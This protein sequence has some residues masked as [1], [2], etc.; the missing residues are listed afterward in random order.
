MTLCSHTSPSLLHIPS[1]QDDVLRHSAYIYHLQFNIH[2]NPRNHWIYYCP[3]I[4]L[5]RMADVG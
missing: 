4:Y 2:S 1:T 3:R 5:R